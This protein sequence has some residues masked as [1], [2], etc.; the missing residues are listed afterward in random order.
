MAR[1][2]P[3]P[4]DFHVRVNEE[5]VVRWRNVDL[6][7]RKILIERSGKTNKTS[8]VWFRT[9]GVSAL[10]RTRDRR[11]HYLSERGQKAI[12]PNE[13]VFSLEDGTAI[14]SFKRVL[15]LC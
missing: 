4:S 12:D 8:T 6:E 1:R 3:C 5:T 10:K 7:H 11:L 9:S 15:T 13:R 2:L 14:N